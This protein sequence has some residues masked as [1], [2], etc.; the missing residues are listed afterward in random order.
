M[1]GGAWGGAPEPEPEAD[2]AVVYIFSNTDP[3]AGANLD[4]FLAYGVREGDG[5]DYYLIIQVGEPAEV[6]AP[7]WLYAFWGRGIKRWSPMAAA[8]RMARPEIQVAAL[9]G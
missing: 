1:A 4:F 8:S 5:A 9:S 7:S 2:T 6:R 3:Q